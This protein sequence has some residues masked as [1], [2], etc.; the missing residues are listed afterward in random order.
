MQINK[1][2]KI[3]RKEIKKNKNNKIKK[4]KKQKE[5]QNT[6]IIKIIKKINVKQA[7]IKDNDNELFIYYI[8]IFHHFLT[9]F[10]ADLGAFILYYNFSSSSN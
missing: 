5:H 3:K 7:G 4:H 8:K 9:S 1:L 2:K 6:N 10:I